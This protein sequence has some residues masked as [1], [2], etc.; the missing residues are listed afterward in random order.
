VIY[1]LAFIPISQ[2]SEYY[3]TEFILPSISAICPVQISPFT[4]NK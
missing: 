4:G 1:Y 3:K 2:D